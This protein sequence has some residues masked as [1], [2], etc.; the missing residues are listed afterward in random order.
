MGHTTVIGI[1]G[2]IGSGKSTVSRILRLKGYEVYD[3]DYEAKQLMRP[4]LAVGRMMAEAFGNATFT[5]DGKLNRQYLA[6]TVFNNPDKLHELNMLVHPAVKADLHKRIQKQTE[7]DSSP[8]LL[9]IESAILATSGI[10][11]FCD[12]AWYVE[13]PEEL[14]ISRVM[15]RNGLKRDEVLKRIKAQQKEYI[16]LYRQAPSLHIINN[17]ESCQLLDSINKLL[18]NLQ[19]TQ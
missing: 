4:H 3:C 14:R 11:E 13:A 15:A 17:N 5:D 12:T 7:V 10:I 16:T 9:F 18:E 2:G 19:P 6:E 8:S 1:A